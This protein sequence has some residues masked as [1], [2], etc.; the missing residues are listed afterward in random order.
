MNE[1][2]KKNYV[3]KIKKYKQKLYT[4]NIKANLF[5]NSIL[6]KITIHSHN[7]N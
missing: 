6:K 1:K 4:I 7:I 3:L 2:I 5:I